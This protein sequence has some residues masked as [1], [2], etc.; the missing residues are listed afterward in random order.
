MKTRDPLEALT[1]IWNELAELEEA[2]VDARTRAELEIARLSRNKHRAHALRELYW[3]PEQRVPVMLLSEL[4]KV[5]VMDVASRA[6]PLEL[7]TTCLLCKRSFS[8]AL[9]NRGLRAELEREKGVNPTW[10]ICVHCRAFRELDLELL[11]K[12]PGARLTDAHRAAYQAY[13]RTPQWAERRARALKKAKNKCSMCS[14]KKNLECHH[15]TYER[16]GQERDEDL[17]IICSVCHGA[18]HGH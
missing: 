14:S 15:R 3:D 8:R 11:R 9:K 5:P 7:K 12:K 2:K 6:G 17:L 1:R 16:I 13:L 10:R 18:H 4:F